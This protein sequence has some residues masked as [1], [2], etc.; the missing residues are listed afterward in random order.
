M[1]HAFAHE[2]CVRMYTQAHRCVCTRGTVRAQA[3]LHTDTCSKCMQHAQKLAYACALNSPCVSQGDL[4][5]QRDVVAAEVVLHARH[6]GIRPVHQHAVNVA[7]IKVLQARLCTLAHI[8]WAVAVVEDLRMCHSRCAYLDFT[9]M[10]I[11]QWLAE[12]EC[13]VKILCQLLSSNNKKYASHHMCRH[14]DGTA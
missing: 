2:P 7:A 12:A 1:S 3:E 6:E 5:I 9:D 8:F 10:Y 4:V 11:L 13:R 14:T